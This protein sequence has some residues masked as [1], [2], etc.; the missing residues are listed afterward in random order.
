MRSSSSSA[1]TPPEPG[2]VDSPPTSTIAAPQSS[3]PHAAVTAASTRRCTP[4]SENE[5]GV[6]LITPI[7]DGAGKRSSIGGR[8]FDTTE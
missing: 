5:S 4:P 2:R 7:T 3:I 6:T 1:V 8:A